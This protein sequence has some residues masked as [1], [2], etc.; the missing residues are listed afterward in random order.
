[1]CSEH[2]DNLDLPDKNIVFYLFLFIFQPFFNTF[3][4]LF[5]QLRNFFEN[6]FWFEKVNFYIL[7]GVVRVQ[8]RALLLRFVLEENDVI[9][10]AQPI[11]LRHAVTCYLG[12]HLEPLH[13]AHARRV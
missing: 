1:M 3:T 8:S 7:Y 10:K 11:R 5:F 13:S 4:K 9:G 2:P 6:A 12:V